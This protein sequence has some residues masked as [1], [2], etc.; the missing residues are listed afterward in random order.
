MSDATQWHRRPNPKE[1]C[2]LCNAPV[3]RANGYPLLAEHRAVAPDEAND[4]AWITRKKAPAGWAYIEVRQ[5]E[6]KRPEKKT[7]DSCVL[8]QVPSVQWAE[9]KPLRA[10]GVSEG[11]SYTLQR[12]LEAYLQKRVLTDR[13]IA[14]IESSVRSFRRHRSGDDVLVSDITPE[15]LNNWL[16]AISLSPRTIIKHRGNLLSL[17]RD[18]ADDGKC[19]EPV[20][21]RIRKPRKPKPQPKAWS[22]D[23]LRRV[24]KACDN[25]KGNIYRYGVLT[26]RCVYFGCLA[27]CAYE[28]GLR[29]GNLFALTQSDVR[30]DGTIYIIH[31][32]TGEPHVCS[33]SDM[34]LCLLRQLP[35]DQPLR[36]RDNRSF[37]RRWKSICAAAGVPNGG[38]HRIRKTAATQ[39]WL[40]DEQNPSR[41]QQ[42]LGHLTG[43]MWRHYVD[44]SQGS[45]RPP[46]PP[47]A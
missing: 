22:L 24:F 4:A 1:V 41:V 43:D 7:Q 38:L 33:L 11:G 47:A 5:K 18:A 14:S 46:K 2:P 37:Y 9:P 36:W 45:S 16:S 40:I 15:T 19:D 35:G 31:E 25:M 10:I 39:V 20:N 12:A 34:T 21:R 42:F 29:R 28:T 3:Y 13:S 44:K 23:E 30:D 8:R 17:L 32:K 27:R 6:R 26:P